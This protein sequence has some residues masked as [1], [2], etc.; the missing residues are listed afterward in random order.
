MGL[1]VRE[2]LERLVGRVVPFPGHRG[3]S[4]S[5]RRKRAPEKTHTRG[6]QVAVQR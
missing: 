3:V 6:T 4:D 1:K 5:L 2:L